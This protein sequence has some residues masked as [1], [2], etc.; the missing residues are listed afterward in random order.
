MGYV[1]WVREDIKK[2]KRAAARGNA[3]AAFE[4]AQR[5]ATGRGVDR[6]P[7]KAFAECSYAAGRD[8]PEALNMLGYCYAA[9]LGT[10]ADGEA[11]RRAF[12]RAAKL[13]SA[14]AAYNLA[15]LYAE[16]IGME[17]PDQGRADRWLWISARRGYA[18]A[19]NACACRL[20]EA[21]RSEEERSIA[22]CW[23]RIAADRGDAEAARILSAH[24]RQQR[25]EAAGLSAP[26]LRMVA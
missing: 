18:K 21:D 22:L 25:R 4:L 11:A 24:A 15:V 19:R 9:G 8:L 13:G 7:R 5:L 12:W 16:G 20:L 17:H 23:L 26:C 10:I 6:D 14:V 2:V 3:Q 1:N